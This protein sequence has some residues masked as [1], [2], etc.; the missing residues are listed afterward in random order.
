MRD[1][2]RNK[3]VTDIPEIN[4]VYEPHAAERKSQNPYIVLRQGVETEESEWA[5]FRRIIEVWP[6]VERTSFNRVDELYTKIGVAL[7]RQFLTT[8]TGEV[9]SCLYLGTDGQDFVDEEWDAITRGM[10]F[11]VV[12]L[13][14]VAINETIASDPW[15]E[16]LSIWTENLLWD[17]EVYRNYWPT[18]Y[19]RPS[20]LWRLSD[21]K[22]EGLTRAGIKVRKSLIGHVLGATPNQQIQAIS[23]II[24]GLT[25]EIKIPLDIVSKKYLTVNNPRGNFKVDGLNQGQI[26][27]ELS[28]NT[29]RPKEDVPVMMKVGSAGTL[30]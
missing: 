18:G 12:A 23:D 16:A 21:Y 30:K 20:V 6:Y 3:L 28:R 11:A 4:D 19:V 1:A 9:F 27:I 15:I 13:Q 24:A 14:P 5:G 29:S 25:N 2:I 17:W 10:R 8:L 7:D 22:V 26:L